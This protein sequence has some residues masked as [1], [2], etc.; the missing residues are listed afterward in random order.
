MTRTLQ[1]DYLG[2]EELGRCYTAYR[3]RVSFPYTRPRED[4]IKLRDA[5]FIGSGQTYSV[6]GPE[7][8]D[9]QCV[10]YV[11]DRNDSSD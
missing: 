4:V 6:R 5:G 3:Y 10:Y 8:E 11:E 2:S 7:R 9:G 1:I